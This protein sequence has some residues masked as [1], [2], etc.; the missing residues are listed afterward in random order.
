MIYYLY[1]I[2]TI[3]AIHT[4][5]MSGVNVLLRPKSL[6]IFLRESVIMAVKNTL[7]VR[8]AKANKMD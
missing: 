2:H 3:H 5:R 4:G 7:S 6:E 8:R 1:T